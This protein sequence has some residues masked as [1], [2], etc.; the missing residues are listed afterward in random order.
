MKR[1][2]HDAL[3]NKSG[4]VSFGLGS[5]YTDALT[6][7]IAVQELH[8]CYFQLCNRQRSRGVTNNGR[9]CVV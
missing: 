6:S 5:T 1:L 2:V 4:R 3:E 8:D 7:S 9:V